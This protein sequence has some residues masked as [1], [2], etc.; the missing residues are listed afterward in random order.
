MEKKRVSFTSCWILVIIV[1]LICAA[2]ASYTYYVTYAND[3][4]LFDVIDK[5]TAPNGGSI[6]IVVDPNTD[7]CY[8]Y[9]SNSNQLTPYMISNEDKGDSVQAM[10]NKD[11]GIH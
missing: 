1:I 11:I 3:R 2:M 4:P 10:Y 6:Y 9:V 7:L 5:S 8:Y